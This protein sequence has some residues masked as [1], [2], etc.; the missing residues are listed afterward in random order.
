MWS[1]DMWR[2]GRCAAL[3]GNCTHDPPEAMINQL[4]RSPGAVA[5]VDRR[6]GQCLLM[7]YEDL[8]VLDGPQIWIDNLYL[9]AAV[10]DLGPA[11]RANSSIGLLSV[12]RLDNKDVYPVGEAARFVTRCTFQG[13]GLG[14]SIASWGNEDVYIERAPLKPHR[15]RNRVHHNNRMH[16]CARAPARDTE[17]QI[18]AAWMQSA[19]CRAP[20]HSQELKRQTC[21]A[22]VMPMFLAALP[23]KISMFRDGVRYLRRNGMALRPNLCRCRMCLCEPRR[24]RRRPA[25]LQR[26][27][28]GDQRPGR[29]VG[30]HREQHVL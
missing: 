28:V 1:R 7:A 24:S 26:L 12:P 8:L 3:Q 4:R 15:Q 27:F 9:R 13:D 21:R 16:L 10:P 18:S 11:D 2:R 29:C 14:P 25:Q 30:A 5:L 23:V 17:W 22:W 19:C 6:P 20:T